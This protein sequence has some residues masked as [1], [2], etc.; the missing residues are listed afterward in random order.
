MKSTRRCCWLSLEISTC[1]PMRMNLISS[2]IEDS[3]GAS[4][5]TKNTNAARSMLTGAS[6]AGSSIAG[7]AASIREPIDGQHRLRQ[8]FNN[9]EEAERA[10]L[11]DAEQ[12]THVNARSVSQWRSQR[13]RARG[14]RR[15]ESATAWL[16][17]RCLKRGRLH[18]DIAGRRTS[19]GSCTCRRVA[20]RSHARLIDTC[21]AP[22]GQPYPTG[23]VTW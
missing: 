5:L 14:Q 6:F 22:A 18:V 13:N 17:R 19:S 4:A 16:C 3:R 9:D 2:A 23:T 11:L 12:E 21:S 7:T 1:L 10:G 20:D 15:V 8:R